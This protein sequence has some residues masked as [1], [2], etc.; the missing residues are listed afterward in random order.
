MPRTT[1]DNQMSWVRFL[2]AL[3]K[4]LTTGHDMATSYMLQLPP[5]SSVSRY[6]NC[7]EVLAWAESHRHLDIPGDFFCAFLT[8]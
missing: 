1:A 4:L 8:G 2:P 6:W 3:G 5:T 7:E